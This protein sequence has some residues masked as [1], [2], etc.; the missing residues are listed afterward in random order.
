MKEVLLPKLGQTMEEGTV[1][2]WHKKEGDAVR[3][4]EVI[5][6]IGTDKATLEVEAYVEGVLRKIVVPEGETV[7]CNY[8]V[9]LVGSKDEPMPD[10]EK[11]KA[12]FAA[13]AAEAA[14]AEAPAEQA[15]AQPAPAPAPAP[16]AAPAPA[17]PPAVEAAAP[18]TAGSAPAAPAGRVF[19][20]PRA[21]SVA[22]EMQVP[23]E[24]IQGT[25]PGGRIV[26][27]DVRAY[28]EATSRATPTARELAFQKGIDLRG[29]TPAG[30]E[31]RIGKADVLAAAAA[32]APAKAAAKA[33]AEA[34]PK[35]AAPEAA[36]AGEVPLTAMRKVIAQRMSQSKQQA[37]HFYLFAEADMGAA[38]DLRKRLNALGGPKITFTDLIVKAAAMAL[39]RH[40]R[41]N[42]RWEGGK[43]LLN[44]AV[45]I[46]LAVSVE[47]GLFVPVLRAADSKGLFQIAGDREGLIA[48]ARS[49]KL[50]PDDYTGGSVTLSNLGMFGV[51][52][53]APIINPG[54]SLIIGTGAIKDRVVPWQGGIHVRPIMVITV[55]ADHRSVDGALAAVFLK[56]MRELLEAPEALA[57]A[58]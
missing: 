22:R 2:K 46:G 47:D 20:S 17:V 27:R 44:A 4:G 26:E 11:L 25:G 31:G 52:Y 37:P 1:E 32:P 41:V 45:N 7:P 15:P 54:E 19:S 24:L 39:A 55:C 42:C 5:F 12:H 6:E 56:E 30:G 49:G 3:K 33:A 53:F 13:R 57:A 8:L 51:D 36:K 38:T 29:L 58:P 35:T 16:A 9:A 21:R 23:V 34:A 28:A 10:V 40:P 50:G 48:K 43:I 18:E 14:G